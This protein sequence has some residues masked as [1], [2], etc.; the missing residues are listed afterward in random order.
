MSTFSRKRTAFR[1]VSSFIFAFA[2]LL[3]SGVNGQQTPTVYEQMCGLNAEWT[4]K[5]LSNQ[6]LNQRVALTDDVALIQMHLGLVVE[7]L[8]HANVQ[9]LTPKQQERR[10]EGIDILARYRERGV[11]P[12]NSHHKSRTPY[13]IDDFGVAC[14]VGQI[15]VETGYG[16]FAEQ[17]R[18]EHNNGYISELDKTYPTLG[19]WADTYGFT[20]EE[21]AWIQP[22][23]QGG[24][25]CV[26]I[27][28]TTVQVF[29][30]TCY[31]VCD[32]YVYL[33]QPQGV[34]PFT[35][36]GGPMSCPLCA[37]TYTWTV[38][39]AIG[40]Q[41]IHTATLVA[42]PQMMLVI[43]TLNAASPG[44]CDG[45][46]AAS[47]TGGTPPYNY[48]WADCSTLQNIGTIDTLTG[49][50]D[51]SGAI[52]TV[53]DV[54]GCLETASCVM[55]PTAPCNTAVQSTAVDA[56]CAGACDGSVT[57]TASSGTTPYGFSNDGGATF[58]YPGTST[59]S[60]TNL[61]LL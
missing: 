19:K 34:A 26:V 57:L 12:S 53:A 51:G 29:N 7:Q 45:A 15:V 43:D 39:D 36:S 8:Q 5:N 32:G 23:Y 18:A 14:A 38:T 47:V 22:T 3:P 10:A 24:G 56:S 16:E 21:L 42:P 28:G 55:I 13:F 1:A 61:I 49:I 20:M 17:I 52:L 33:P 2:L 50:C 46:L 35:Y 59:Y 41:T 11:F 30:P 27:T 60:F 44:M 40:T 31:S 48:D 6:Q 54:H 4:T 9:H 25:N 37:G 58:T